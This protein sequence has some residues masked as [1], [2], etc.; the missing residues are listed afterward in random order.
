MR[1][2]ATTERERERERAHRESPEMVST[3]LAI[4]VRWLQKIVGIDTRC[5]CIKTFM[6]ANRLLVE[7][8]SLLGELAAELNERIELRNAV[9]LM[10]RM[11]SAER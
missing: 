4:R 3:Q 1:R 9:E 5:Y 8:V 2:V 11:R 10:R 7:L 6:K